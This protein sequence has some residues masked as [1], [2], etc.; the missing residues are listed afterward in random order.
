MD[1]YTQLAFV[2]DDMYASIRNWHAIGAGPFYI[3]DLSAIE[4]GQITERTYR[5]EPARDTFRAAIGFLGTTQIEFIEPT[6]DAPSLFR[7]VLA[8]NKGEVLHHM[9]AKVSV[10]TP[11]R[12]DELSRCYEGLGMELVSAMATPAG[13]RAAFYDGR[14][15][16]GCFLEIAEKGEHTFECVKL[17]HLAHLRQKQLPMIM[18]WPTP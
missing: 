10:V 16:V 4:N 8:K 11:A 9:Q 15:M 6:N 17:M 5:G 1:D 12:F 3:V 13:A 2:T 18:D 14:D 7:E